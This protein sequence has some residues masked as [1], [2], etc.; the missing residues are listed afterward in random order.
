MFCVV[1]GIFSLFLDWN[2]PTLLMGSSVSVAE[3]SLTG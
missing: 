3:G 2:L 1:V